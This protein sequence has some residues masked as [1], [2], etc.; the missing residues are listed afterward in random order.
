MR[1]SLASLL[2]LIGSL[3]TFTASLAWWE[4][5]SIRDE[6]GFVKLG[7]TILAKPPVQQAIADNIRD[8]VQDVV[9]R[10]TS[11]PPPRPV[12]DELTLKA[13][14]NLSTSNVASDALR[15]THRL[16]L[17]VADLQ[18]G[19]D[20]AVQ[21]DDDAIVLDLHQLVVNL[22]KD[23]QLLDPSARGS[24]DVPPD[25]GRIVIVRSREVQV[26]IDALKAMDKAAPLLIAL[27][28]IFF[29]LALLIAPNKGLALM[30]IGGGVAGAA[31]LR[32]FLLKGPL[33]SL[34]RDLL[35][36]VPTAQGAGLAS[37]DVFVDS[38]GH[39]DTMVLI[40]GVAV[41]IAGLLVAVLLH[42]TY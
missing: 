7:E 37:Y 12:L 8:E 17:R 5:H 33:A 28:F 24:I 4:Q 29:G 10:N 38:F 39:Q 42:R 3:L 25:V 20:S 1:A 9:R 35:A 14:E 16:V 31:L 21:R 13:V 32:F 15:T 2:I 34:I 18:E 23:L 36:D 11:D 40:A 30:L 26:A 19:G 27:P 22:T 41:A 6:D